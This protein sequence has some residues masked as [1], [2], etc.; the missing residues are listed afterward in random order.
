MKNTKTAMAQLGI[1]IAEMAI[2]IAELK[3]QL[4]N[5]VSPVRMDTAEVVVVRLN[6]KLDKYQLR[7]AELEQI[8]AE[9]KMEVVAISDV[10]DKLERENKQ[11]KMERDAL[12]QRVDE[13]AVEQSMAKHPPKKPSKKPYT[14]F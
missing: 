1:I 4:N 13:S 7:V 2:E 8:N 12:Q 3:E 11:L 14:P 5:T 9:R 10:A 6:E